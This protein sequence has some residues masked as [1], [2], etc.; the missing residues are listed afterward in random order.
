MVEHF[1]GPKGD[2]LGEHNGTDGWSRAEFLRTFVPRTVTL[3]AAATVV[4]MTSGCGL[5]KSITKNATEGA[6]EGAEEWAKNHPEEKAKIERAA[7]DAA[8][9]LRDL[10]ITAEQAKQITARMNAQYER[11]EQNIDQVLEAAGITAS[12][13]TRLRGIFGPLIDL[14]ERLK[15][16]L[17]DLTSML[18]YFIQRLAAR[19]GQAIAELLLFIL[20]FLFIERIRRLVDELR[21]KYWL[22]PWLERLF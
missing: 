20:Y 3:G 10:R 6:L 4:G 13:F 16:N 1:D 12:I 21:R 18:T 15:D 7:D 9:I 8:A 17:D 19:V 11:N 5:F 22:I 2:G 14:F